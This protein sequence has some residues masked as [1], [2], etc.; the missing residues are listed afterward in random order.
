LLVVPY[1]VAT[2]TNSGSRDATRIMIAVVELNFDG[3]IV[4][5]HAQRQQMSKIRNK[6]AGLA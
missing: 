2:F 5:D 3:I 6:P 1:F 4:L